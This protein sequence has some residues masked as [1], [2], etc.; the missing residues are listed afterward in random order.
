M[1]PRHV[2]VSRSPRVPLD[3]E[4]KVVDGIFLSR[5]QCPVAGCFSGNDNEKGDSGGDPVATADS[6]THHVL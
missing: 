6:L 2:C 1:G 5:F 4:E 3:L